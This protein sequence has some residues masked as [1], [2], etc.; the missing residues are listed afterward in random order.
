ML[1]T[2]VRL[3][4]NTGRCGVHLIISFKYFE[5]V[6][7][8]NWY[9]DISCYDT[10]LLFCNGKYYHMFYYFYSFPYGGLKF[11]N[12]IDDFLLY[13]RV[14][15]YTTIDGIN[16][17]IIIICRCMV[18]KNDI[19][20]FYKNSPTIEIMRC[21]QRIRFD[22]SDGDGDRIVMILLQCIIAIL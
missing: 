17:H 3:R 19:I 18:D 2:F 22:K 16:Y 10:I 7:N 14:M 9:T 8:N 15:G 21:K 4:H 13:Y 12:T 5:Y 1:Y 20:F 11:Y 6:L